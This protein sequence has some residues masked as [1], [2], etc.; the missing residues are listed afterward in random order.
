MLFFVHVDCLC[1]Y[2]LMLKMMYHNFVVFVC[3]LF[4]FFAS[5]SF[6]NLSVLNRKLCVGIFFV[7]ACSTKVI[8]AVLF[9][10]LAFLSPLVLM[11][12]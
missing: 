6:L 12:S 9:M 5:D 7:C 4:L 11:Y 3:L 8:S 1:I 10:V 2:S